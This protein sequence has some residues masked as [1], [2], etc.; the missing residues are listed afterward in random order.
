MSV[1]ERVLA[2]IRASAE[3]RDAAE[4]AFCEAWIASGPRKASAGELLD[5]AERAGLPITGETAHAR[6]TSLGRWLSASSEGPIEADT[7]AYQIEKAGTLDGYRLW[8]ITAR[9]KCT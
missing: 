1:L 5:L 6:Q 7:I 9:P 3:Q 4:R 2:K 8:K